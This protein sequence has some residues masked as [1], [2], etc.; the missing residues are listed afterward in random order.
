MSVEFEVGVC[1]LNKHT[2]GNHI[3][4]YLKRRDIIH[5]IVSWEFVLEYDVF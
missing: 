2:F 5:V 3:Y 1:S 4:F